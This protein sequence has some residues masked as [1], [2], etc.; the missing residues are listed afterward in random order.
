MRPG[1]LLASALSLLQSKPPLTEVPQMDPQGLVDAALDAPPSLMGVA[2]VLENPPVILKAT[3]E[4]KDATLEMRA[5]SD[6]ISD[7]DEATAAFEAKRA[8]QPTVDATIE[9]VAPFY[10]SEGYVICLEGLEELRRLTMEPYKKVTLMLFLLRDNALLW[11][12]KA[13]KQGSDVGGDGGAKG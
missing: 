10:R 4:Q 6:A 11:A 5:F 3:L 9:Q 13:R 1:R 7:T 8:W 2:Q 12:K